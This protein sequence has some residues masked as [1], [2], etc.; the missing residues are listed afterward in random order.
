MIDYTDLPTMD[1]ICFGKGAC[2]DC[3]EYNYPRP[4]PCGEASS[5]DDTAEDD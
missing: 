1:E 3:M 4:C 5:Y 2:E